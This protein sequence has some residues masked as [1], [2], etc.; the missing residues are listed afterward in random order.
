[1]SVREAL[2]YLRQL[3]DLYALRLTARRTPGVRYRRVA[4]S[5]MRA[6]ARPQERPAPVPVGSSS[7][8]E[9]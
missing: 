9:P 1:M 7:I 3:W 5:E 2:G 8:R 4:E 6:F